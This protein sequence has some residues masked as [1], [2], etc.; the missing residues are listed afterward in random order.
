MT[1]AH[2]AGFSRLLVSPV[3]LLLLSDWSYSRWIV[4]AAVIVAIVSDILDG[5][6]ARKF[7][8]VSNF[9]VYLDT[10]IDKV[11][12]CGLLVVMSAT[13]LTPAWI[14]FTI[15]VREFIVMGLRAYVASEGLVL[16]AHFWGSLKTIF[17]FAG[18]LGV[19]LRI[20]Y[21]HWL[22]V[23]GVFLA[24]ISGADYAFKVWNHVSRTK[25]GI[26]GGGTG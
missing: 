21:S 2:Y 25:D 13:Q 18:V 7:K 26:I 5:Y 1:A 23:V 4:I 20:P 16:S 6:L 17:L 19:L 9:G 10:T 12:V 24:V 11:F 3:T 22:L 8:T 14:T 15:V